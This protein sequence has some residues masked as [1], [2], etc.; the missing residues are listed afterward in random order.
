L[1]NER[2]VIGKKA[3]TY[4]D[5][6]R[7]SE[8]GQD[9]LHGGIATERARVEVMNTKGTSEYEGWGSA[10]K[11]ALEPITVARK[12]LSEKTIAANVLKWGTGGINIDG[13]RVELNGD[14][15][16]A[17]N[18]RPSQTGLDDGY[19][20]EKANNHIEQGRFPANL[21]HDGSQMVLDLFPAKAGAAAPVMSGQKGKS[22]GIYGDFEQKGDN[23]ASF[24]NDSG[25]AARFFYCAKASKADRN[26]GLDGCKIISYICTWR[27][28][29]ITKEETKVELLVDTEQLHRKGIDEFGALQKSGTEWSTELFGKFIMA[30]FLKD[31]KYTTKTKINSITTS[32]ILN[33]LHN[34]ITSGN[35]QGVSCEMANGLNLVLLVEK[36]NQLLSTIS[37]KMGFAI[38]ANPALLNGQLEINVSVEKGKS[39]HPTVKPTKL[40]Q[41]LVRLVTPVGGT[42]YDPFTGSGSTG[43]ACKSEGFNFIGSEMEEHSCKIANARI[44]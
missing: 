44:K 36:P 32:E 29:N 14:Y 35:I 34:Y 18:D 30:Q 7:D 9:G 8:T 11:P 1:G 24:R 38:N 5:I 28:N 4:A 42:V 20:S 41:Y 16:C 2:E 15:K 13:C 40:M 25:S 26:S 39:N 6:K 33:C 21:I 17:A 10:L 19:N 3:G 22:N 23:G 12:P 31:F 37:E 43:K 27:E